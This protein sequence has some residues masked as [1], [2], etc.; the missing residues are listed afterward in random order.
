MTPT[1]QLN[2]RQARFVAEY[3]LEPNA[4]RAAL[5]AGY[6]GSPATLGVTGFQLLRNP[7]VAKA[8]EAAREKLADSLQ[9]TRERVMLEYAR[10]GFSD[11]S[12]VVHWDA[13]LG[14]AVVDWSELTEDQRRAVVEVSDVFGADGRQGLRIKLADKRAALDSLVRMQGWSMERADHAAAEGLT[15]RLIVEDTA[16]NVISDVSHVSGQQERKALT[17]P[18]VRMDDP[19]VVEA[20]QSVVDAGDVHTEPV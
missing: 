9:I 4:T 8:L 2:D 7:K 3:Q 18:V 5:R 16:G 13:K 10:M 14:V 6:G 12:N 11:L 15:L 19:A 20:V 17:S 1:D